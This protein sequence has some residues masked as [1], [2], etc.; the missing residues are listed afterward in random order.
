M[1]GANAQLTIRRDAAA[2]VQQREAIMSLDDERRVLG[3]RDSVRLCASLRHARTN[4]AQAAETHPYGLTARPGATRDLGR[5]GR[6]HNGQLALRAEYIRC[7]EALRGYC[8]PN[9]FE[10]QRLLDELLTAR[11][12]LV[13]AGV[14]R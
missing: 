6:L 13:E 4:R 12:K 7:A 11:K 8:G 14:I 5:V 10:Q 9:A 1:D 2:D 3:G